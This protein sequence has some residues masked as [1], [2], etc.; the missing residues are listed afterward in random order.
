MKGYIFLICS[1]M[2]GLI[3]YTHANLEYKGFSN[4]S[5][6]TGKCYEDYTRVNGTLA[7]Q[8]ERQAEIA[9]ADE[10][11][12]IRGLWGGCAACHGAEGQGM[13]AFPQ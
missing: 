11:S 12:S 13:G 6:C 5:A 7:E 3:M 4:V 9:A 10:F 1:I 2:F 8:L